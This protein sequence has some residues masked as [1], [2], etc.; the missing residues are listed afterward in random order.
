M[1]TIRPFRGLRFDP[2]KSGDLREVTCPPYD[3]ISDEQRQAYLRANEHNVIR[4]ELPREGED[5]YKQAGEVLQSWMNE[6]ILRQD[7]QDSY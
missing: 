2:Q 7:E 5:P 6:E 4:L 3:I 1:A